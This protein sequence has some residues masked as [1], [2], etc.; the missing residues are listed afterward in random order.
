MLPL[1]LIVLSVVHFSA[2][3]PDPAQQAFIE[4]TI[5]VDLD[6]KMTC[7]FEILRKETLLYVDLL[8]K[9]TSEPDLSLR[10]TSP[11]GEFSEW[12][13]GKGELSMEHNVSESVQET[14]K[15]A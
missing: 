9:A 2:V 7:F 6:S 10:L 13:E 4:R 5:T 8:P 1:L 3:F 12:V 14:T 11:S 15:S